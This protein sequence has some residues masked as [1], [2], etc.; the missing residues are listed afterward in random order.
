MI[1]PNSAIVQFD[2]EGAYDSFEQ[3][4]FKFFIVR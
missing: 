2:L 4:P 1:E 3:Q